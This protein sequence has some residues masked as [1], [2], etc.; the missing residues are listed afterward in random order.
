M[1]AFVI[2]IHIIACAL[3]IIIIL[4]QAGRGGGLVSGFSGI[5]SM[6]GTNTNTFLTK[7]TTVL[8]ILFFLTCLSLAAF[9]AKRS[10]SI[11]HNAPITK[12]A[13]TAPTA[14]PNAPTVTT[15]APEEKQVTADA[16]TKSK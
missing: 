7:A 2:A 3:L 13:Q 15:T 12:V 11:M 6:F 4:I 5:E 10:K 16:T 9:S 1:T 8:S 14:K